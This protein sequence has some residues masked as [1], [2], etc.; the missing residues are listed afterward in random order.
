MANYMGFWVYPHQF[1]KKLTICIFFFKVFCRN[2][3]KF[4][5]KCKYY[6]LSNLKF[7]FVI[8]TQEIQIIHE[9]KFNLFFL[10]IIVLLNYSLSS[11]YNIVIVINTPTTM[12]N[13]FK[14]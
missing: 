14:V 7:S 11:I 6:I 1:L 12:N 4:E 13:Q 10:N 9:N 3:L 8:S 5:I 2:N